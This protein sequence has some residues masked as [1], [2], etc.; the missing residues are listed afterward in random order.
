MKKKIAIVLA[1]L[2]LSTM[3]MTSCDEILSLIPGFGDPPDSGEPEIYVVTYIVDDYRINIDQVTEGFPITRPEDPT[4]DGYAFEGW[5]TDEAYTQEYDFSAIPTGD[6]KLYNGI[7]GKV[8]V[9][10]SE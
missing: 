6:V 2:I 3:M 7:V 8:T 1:I 5:Y 9:V 4:R 10:V